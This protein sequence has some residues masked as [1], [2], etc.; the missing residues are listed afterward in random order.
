[1]LGITLE[2]LALL[3]SDR[4]ASTALTFVAWIVIGLVAG[5]LG[6]LILNKRHPHVTTY[7]LLGIVG[8]IVGGFLSS[9]LGRSSRGTSDTY[10]LMV[11][12]VSAIVFVIVYHAVFRR[13][14]FL[15]M[16]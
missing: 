13:K 14:R 7:I 9:L 2:P 6:S 8:A 5:Y 4:Q 10:S 11:A 16:D 3:V 1:M 12:A 15:S